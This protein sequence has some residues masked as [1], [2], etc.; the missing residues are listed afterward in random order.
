VRSRGNESMPVLDG[1]HLSVWCR[2]CPWQSQPRAVS[3]TDP[4]AFEAVWAAAEADWAGHACDAGQVYT[5][6]ESTPGRVA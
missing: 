4:L 5:P 1:G 2:F 3:S 6:P